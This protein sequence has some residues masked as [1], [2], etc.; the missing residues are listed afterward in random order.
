MVAAVGHPRW[1]DSPP[2]PSTYR[3][4]RGRSISEARAEQDRAAGGRDRRLVR[5][6]DGRISTGSIELKFLGGR[7]VYAYL[8]YTSDGR[9]VARYVGEAPGATREERLSAAWAA[10]HA[11]GL[12]REPDS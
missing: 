2:D 8:R 6:T 5:L 10:A 12:L 11:Q 9:T 7:R 1:A 4:P 3:A